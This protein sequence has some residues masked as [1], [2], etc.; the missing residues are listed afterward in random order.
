MVD[1]CRVGGPGGVRLRAWRTPAEEEEA[2]A[3]AEATSANQ[4]LYE[5]MERERQAQCG[6]GPVTMEEDPAM[7]AMVG[8]DADVDFEV[9]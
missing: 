9:I 7:L 1:L 5:E 3:E 2:K 6:D 4:E 8:E